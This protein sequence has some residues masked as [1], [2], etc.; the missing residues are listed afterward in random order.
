M[1]TWQNG[2]G[3]PND[4]AGGHSN[5]LFSRPPENGKSKVMGVKL[6][7]VNLSHEHVVKEMQ[8]ALA[9]DMKE[10]V[11]KGAKS[12]AKSLKKGMTE[13]K[14]EGARKISGSDSVRDT[15]KREHWSSKKKHTG[16]LRP[17]QKFRADK[18]GFAIAGQ[19][20]DPSARITYST[21]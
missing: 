17:S 18:L 21:G 2:T 10:G 5:R 16:Q 9:D 8:R 1:F 12:T 19:A 3:S 15:K 20:N 11:T 6:T 7:H 4:L 14:K 13:L